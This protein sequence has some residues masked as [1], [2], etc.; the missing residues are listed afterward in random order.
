[1]KKAILKTSGML[2]VVGLALTAMLF[3]CKQPT[4]PEDT[5]PPAEVTELKA[6]AG[7]GKVSLSWTNPNDEDLYQVKIT[8]ASEEGAIPS[9]IYKAVSSGQADTATISELTAGK[10][11][12]FTV[13][14]LDKKGNESA[15]TK[16]EG[17]TPLSGVT[18]SITLSQTPA[19][20]TW[21]N[22]NVTVNVTSSTTI[23]EAKWLS[24]AKTVQEVFASGN[25]ITGGTFEVTENGTYSVAVQDNDGRREVETIEIKNI[26]KT[27]PEAPKNFAAG[28]SVAQ[29]KIT[30]SW[31]AVTDT[32]S[33]VKEL[34]LEYKKA[35]AAQTP[36]T[37]AAGD[38]TYV[39]ENIDAD[40]SS[41]VFS[42][43]VVDNAENKSAPST[44]NIVTKALPEVFTMSVDHSKVWVKGDRKVTVTITG[45]NLTKASELKI[46]V[47][48]LGMVDCPLTSDETVSCEVE[49]PAVQ[50]DYTLKLRMKKNGGAFEELPQTVTVKA[51]VPNV[52]SMS[53]TKQDGSSF[54][55]DRFDP[56]VFTIKEN[57]GGTMNMVLNGN[58]FDVKGPI[59]VS[60]NGTFYR[61]TANAAG[62]ECRLENISIPTAAGVYP[63][64]LCSEV[65]GI[66]TDVETGYSLRVIGDIVFSYVILPYYAAD[67]E[68]LNFD[69]VLHGENFDALSKAE[70]ENITCAL[71]GSGS[72][73][74]EPKVISSYTIKAK[75]IMPDLPAGANPYEYVD[76]ITLA[77]KTF[78]ARL[79]TLKIEDNYNGKIVKGYENIPSDG[80]I[81]I[82]E[83]VTEVK[84]S[85]FSGCSGIT[86]VS[87]SGCTSL[88]SIGKWAFANCS[89]LTSVNFPAS[90]TSIGD[91]A[92]IGCTGLTSVSLSGC[93][94][95][96][97][98]G[99]AAFA[100]CTGLTN[101]SLSSCTSL[102][103]IGEKAFDGCSS[104]T[105]VNFPAS[106][107]S[108]GDEAFN[109]CSGLTSVSLSGCTSLTSIGEKAFADCSGLTSVNF[110]ASLTSIDSCAFA[111]CSGLTSATFADA[112]GWAV[113]NDDKYKNKV[114]DI[115]QSNLENAAIAAKYLHNT[116]YSKFWKKN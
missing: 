33:G 99:W 90:L 75:Y 53:V 95:L 6:V 52:S 41:Y 29:K 38:T 22:G 13:K 115:Q 34:K 4:Q 93:T 86:S 28:Y 40:A 69:I 8:A 3:G 64:K 31:N 56:K 82:P 101:V 79:H 112:T 97:S 94:S 62:T 21:T 110:P 9:P 14:T 107:T 26:D 73:V 116:Y 51:A 83:V 10:E 44:C 49:I 30:L 111:N 74:T 89:G 2:L 43:S 20:E 18:M 47:P 12:T 78:N 37:I 7:V 27:P 25:A 106:L 19:A 50:G 87:L 68:L 91:E 103:S 61:G 92:F 11:Y 67:R 66:Q 88:T 42:L 80:K 109:N 98:I 114:A 39:L 76:I 65:N 16:T 58:D 17:I 5:T 77:G 48:G 46:A 45:A 105:S 104:L 70:L 55:K 60:L 108:I 32:G 100:R 35:G 113:Y 102:T 36:V 1:M 72:A 23:K 96:T 24:G 84:D 85:A 59:G 81:I 15:G 63:I 71:N 54:D 57:V